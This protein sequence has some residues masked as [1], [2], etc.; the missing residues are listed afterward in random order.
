[1]W[2][3][4][5]LAYAVAVMQR[6]SFGVASGLATER[7]SAGASV[8][9]LFVV[10]QLLTYAA[11]QVPA[12]VL[13]DRF[14][15]RLVVSCGAVLMCL[16]QLDLAFSTSLVSAMIA[17]VLVG[18]GDAM[19]FTA[20]LR[21]LPAWFSPGRLP[22]LNQLTGMLGQAG[23]LMSSIPLAAL[24]ATA[25]WTPSFAAAAGVSAVVAVMIIVVLRNAPP[26]FEE[27]VA[28]PP[29]GVRKQVA[30]V[31]H[32]PAS[33]LA[34]WIHWMCSFWPM[35][36]TLMWGYPFLL[37][38]LGYSQ[39][40]ASGLFTV[41]VLAG[42]PFAPLIGLISRRAPLQRTNLAMLL[43]L[44]CA[45]PWLAVLLWPGVA[46]IWLLV[47]LM[48]GLAASG[49][50]S[51]IGFD[52][53]RAANP[54]R[55]IG[56]A[57]GVVI[58]GGFTAVLVNVLVIGV[59]LD[60]MGGYSL[61]S[62]RWAMATQFL[63]WVV[64]VIGAYT[65]REQ[66][67]RLDRERGVRHPTLLAVVR[68]EWSNLGVEWRIFRSPAA[69]GPG[70]GSLQLTLGDGRTIEVAA[71]LP[72]TGG[73]LAAIDV[74]PAD[75]SALWWHQRISDYLALV[76]AG[77]LEIGS[78]EVRCPDPATTARVRAQITTDLAERG[79]MLTFE[80]VSRSRTAG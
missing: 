77:E 3:L 1:M 40:V 33:R 18:A 78:V 20:V 50:G 47:V 53:A 63:F 11:M 70:T 23:Q 41:L 58:I 66:A 43:S 59:V 46:P 15:T 62:F 57:S 74:P 12:G 37:Y 68:R 48:I 16:G 26:G 30:D 54:L 17:R 31:V 45:L 71:V 32:E 38:G 44:M 7:F 75:A 10:V 49:P 25:G 73:R 80:V 34:F 29:P 76:D 79:A 27:P 6:T 72:G 64:G 24:L 35:V 22:V 51:S 56:T 5:V 19:T 55:H 69:V 42:I 28:G 21:I 13:T 52:V 2:G 9:S 61:T 65:T 36:F 8:V 14:G 67:R 4:G 60:L 39:P